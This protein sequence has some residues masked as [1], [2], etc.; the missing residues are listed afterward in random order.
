MIVGKAPWRVVYMVAITLLAAA[1]MG[2]PASTGPT[3]PSSLE[4]AL[5]SPPTDG[6]TEA[7]TCRDYGGGPLV[8]EDSGGLQGEASQIAYNAPFAVECGLEVERVEAVADVGAQLAAMFEASNITWDVITSRTQANIVDF[9]PKG[10]LERIDTSLYTDVNPDRL[11]PNTLLEYGV[12]GEIDAVVLAYQDGLFASAPASWADF[13]DTTTF[14]GPRMVNNWG[15]PDVTFFDALL[16]DGVA[17]EDLTPIDY[18]RALQVLDRIKPDLVLYESGSQMVQ[19]MLNREAVMCQCTDGR[20]GQM[21]RAGGAMA[22]SW[23]GAI[24]YPNYFAVV[25]NAPNP[26]LAQLFV[27]STL[28]PERAATF[29]SVIGYPTSVLESVDYLTEAQQKALSIHPDNLPKTFF[30]TQDQ[31]KW[32]GEHYDEINEV[33]NNWLQAP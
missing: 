15:G 11:A 5:A 25:K 14:P 20:V 6:P 17:P 7:K 30:L 29:T 27:R 23:E 8:V 16:A 2:S 31:I 22:F 13:F 4:T 26:E 12:G 9:G 1:C 28:R 33:W 18:D 3:S 21:N 19:Q 24:L 10:W 32:V